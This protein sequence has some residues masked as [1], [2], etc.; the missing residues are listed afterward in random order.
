MRDPNRFSRVLKWEAERLS[1]LGQRSWQESGPSKA[2][3]RQKNENRAKKAHVEVELRTRSI[4]AAAPPR[5]VDEL[6]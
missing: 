3:K 5:R 2:F 1:N 6:G 4:S